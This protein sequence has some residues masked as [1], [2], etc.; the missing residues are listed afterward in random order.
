LNN[1]FLFRFNTDDQNVKNGISGFSSFFIE[2]YKIKFGKPT[3]GFKFMFPLPEKSS[4]CKRTNLFLR[5]MVRKDELDFGLWNGINKNQLIIPVDTHIARICKELR[6]TKRKNVS[7]PMAEEITNNL[8]KY[9]PIDPV[10]YDFAL[11]H[12]GMR[13]LQF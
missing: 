10:K 9:D 3:T 6:L 12:I 7:W 8:K 1:L 13:K 11:C 2:N 5:W 4:A